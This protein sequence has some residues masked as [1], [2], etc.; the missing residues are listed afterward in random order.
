MNYKT[1]VHSRSRNFVKNLRLAQSTAFKKKKKI[2]VLWRGYKDVVDPE[3]PEFTMQVIRERLVHALRT[4][5]KTQ[6]LKHFKGKEEEVYQ[7]LLKEVPR[8]SA[9]KKRKSTNEAEV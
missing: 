2:E 6:K 3:C 5:L 4:I 1:F 9:E 8:S 7:S